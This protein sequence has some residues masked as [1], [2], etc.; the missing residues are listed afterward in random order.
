[1]TICEEPRKKWHISI[2][3]IDSVKV[4]DEWIFSDELLL[5]NDI[6]FPF[7]FFGS[8]PGPE[9]RLYQ[10]KLHKLNSKN[11]RASLTDEPI[12]FARRDAIVGT[13]F[14]AGVGALKLWR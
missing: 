14:T 12:A 7:V 1:M 6:S 10:R 13:R 5:Q 3:K 9:E 2:I 8:V 11:A 4:F